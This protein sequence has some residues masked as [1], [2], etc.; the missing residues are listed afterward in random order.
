M[1]NTKPKKRAMSSEHASE[2]K[3]AGHK[4]E[5]D[6]ARII[7]GEVNRGSHTDKKDV[8]DTHHRSH[9]V[10]AGKWWQ[11]FLYS[12]NRLANNT[13]L[14]GIGNVANLMVQCLDVYP[15]HRDKYEKDKK[16]VKQKLQPVMRNLLRELQKQNIFRAFLD[17]SMFDGGNAEYLSI[18]LGKAKENV[19]N[20]QFHIFYKDD[21]VNAIEKYVD[22]RN[23]KARTVTQNDDQKIIFYSTLHNKNIGEIEDRHESRSHYKQMKFRLHAQLVYD[24]LKEHCGEG[25]QLSPQIVVYGVAK[26]KFKLP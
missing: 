3:I 17:K 23:S 18:F 2:V 24:I 16:I 19:Q 6:F 8:I 1:D 9:S 26:K 20:K 21:V 5:E 4:N 14:Q 11:I 12:R 7:G 25:S 22:L 10:K 13:I 15:E